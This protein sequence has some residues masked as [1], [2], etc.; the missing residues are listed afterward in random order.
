MSWWSSNVDVPAI[1]ESCGECAIC[2]ELLYEPF[3]APCG[4]SFCRRCVVASLRH[5][6]KCPSCR[7]TWQ[8]IPA[9]PPVNATLAALLARL[10][11]EAYAA[12]G[13][14]AAPLEHKPVA[15]VG[16]FV[17]DHMLP[18][19]RMKIHVFEPRYRRLVKR[20]LER[21]PPTFGIVGATP[22][23]VMASVFCECEIVECTET[24]D[25][26]YFCEC[27]ARRR[28]RI[29]RD[30]VGDDGFRVACVEDLDDDAAGDADAADAARLVADLDGR[31]DLWL[32]RCR[33][34]GWGASA[35]LDAVLDDLGPR[36][37]AAGP[38]VDAEAY[39]L[40]AAALI[41]PLPPLGV[42][43]EV[44]LDALRATDSLARLRLVDRALALSL[45]H[46]DPQRRA[47]AVLANG[48]LRLARAAAALLLAPLASAHAA[49]A[50]AVARV[51]RPIS[52]VAG[53]Q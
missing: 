40:Y 2:C 36:P 25:G 16:L 53:S 6:A 13:A 43:P 52:D 50:A 22:D 39:G 34:G 8:G 26:R 30:W 35:T 46:L 12:R 29:A 11:P 14:S 28:R 7:T 49:V 51:A 17:L 5:S 3:T 18:K 20:S 44:R 45:R 41:N 48:L 19:Q 47:T 21:D 10:A 31:L 37:A 9:A 42:A 33:A 15:R 27:V 23:N 32:R 1:L 38:A 4:H 24:P